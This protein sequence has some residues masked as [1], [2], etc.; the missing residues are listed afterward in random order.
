MGEQTKT[1]PRLVRTVEHEPGWGWI[2]RDPSTGA[3]ILPNFRWTS[4]SVARGAVDQSRVLSA[5][6][7]AITPKGQP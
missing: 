4:R 2:A 1:R 3:E 7:S 5:S 6:R